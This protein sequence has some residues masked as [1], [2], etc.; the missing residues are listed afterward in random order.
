[1]SEEP[2]SWIR[3]VENLE[4]ENNRLRAEVENLRKD[5]QIFTSQVGQMSE[6][7]DAWKAKYDE[8]V[9]LLGQERNEFGKIETELAAEVESLK[10]NEA[11]FDKS[12]IFWTETNLEL[13][14]ENQRYK[15]ALREII[16]Y[17]ESLQPSPVHPVTYNACAIAYKAIAPEGEKA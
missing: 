14:I 8:V 13:N 5:L 12:Y 6:Q 7:V 16:S 15:R 4:A 10:K 1:M 17:G 3:Q 9:G 11:V 2:I